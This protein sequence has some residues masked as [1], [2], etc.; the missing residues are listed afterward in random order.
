MNYAH[1]QPD[2]DTR[3]DPAEL[4][5]A[6][7]VGLPGF[8]E[9]DVVSSRE[10]LD[11]W[12]NLV[13]ANTDHWRPR[14]T[15]ADDCRTE[16]QFNMMAMATV[17]Q[18]DLGVHYDASSRTGPSDA[19]DSRT[20]LLHGPLSGHGGT[21]ASLPLLYLTIGRR[22]GYP[23]FLVAAKEHLFVRWDDGNAQPFNVECACVGFGSNPDEHYHRWPLALSAKELS[24]G[25]YLTN[26]TSEQEIAHTIASR[27]ERIDQR[28]RAAY[29]VATL[30]RRI[31]NDLRASGLPRDFPPGELIELASPQPREAW[32][33]W[34]LP[35]AQRELLRIV[36]LPANRQTTMSSNPLA[37]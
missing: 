37:S 22:L 12:T 30:S 34:A 26:F 31:L 23:L 19:R 18:R 1:W 3:L 33:H 32:E 6:A 16:S 8:V 7:A 20:Q 17:L 5:F 27:A 4:S 21:C 14:F 24:S 2:A 11:H 15:P 13:A 29:A 10:T 9:A 28:Y 25:F 35:H 36:S